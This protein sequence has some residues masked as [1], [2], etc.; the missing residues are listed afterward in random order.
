MIP[1]YFNPIGA[2]HH[3]RSM[4]ERAIADHLV[5]GRISIKK[6]F[7]VLRPLL[8]CRWIRQTA[9]QPPTE[10]E[11][12]TLPAW[13]TLQEK[14]WIANLLAKKSVAAEAQTIEL[15]E[16]EVKRILSELN[17]YKSCVGAA[18]VDRESNPTELNQ[19]FRDSVLKA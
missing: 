15:H 7:Y 8:A 6:L 3:Y 4:A 14:H 13:V 9:T 19:F 2:L 12:L 5:D 10:F 1:N 17:Q 16:D 11:K 18:S